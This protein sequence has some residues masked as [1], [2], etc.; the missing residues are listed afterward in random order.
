MTRARGLWVVVALAVGCGGGGLKHDAGVANGDGTGVAGQGEASA[1]GQGGGSAAGQGGAGC[2]PSGSTDPV[3]S[4]C[5]NGVVITHANCTSYVAAHCPY[6]CKKSA[7]FAPGSDAFC[8][9]GPTDAGSVGGGAGGGAGSGAAG[10]GGA[11]AAAGLGGGAGSAGG[12]GGCPMVSDPI[13]SSC[14]NGVITTSIYCPPSSYVS[15]T[16]PFGCRIPGGFGFGDFLCN[17]K[18]DGGGCDGACGDARD[19]E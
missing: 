6:G 19:A 5:V 8:N 1:A 18:P 9:D 2:D 3:S 4:E 17:P 7:D 12:A 10:F 15:G 11:D 16:C 13:S 14:T